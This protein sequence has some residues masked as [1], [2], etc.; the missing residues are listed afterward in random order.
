MTITAIAAPRVDLSL[1]L[2]NRRWV[3]RRRPFNHITARHVFVDEVYQQL[4]Q[5]FDD[6]VGPAP[7]VVYNSKHDF[8][9]APISFPVDPRLSPLFSVDLLKVF[10]D[11]FGVPTLNFVTGGVHRH[12]PDSRHGFPHNDI[13]PEI[14]EETYA[15]PG[16]L[17]EVAEQGFGDHVLGASGQSVRAVA[18]IFFVNNE[19]WQR[20]DGGGTGLYEHW[21]QSTADPFTQ[22]PPYSNSIFAFECTPYSYHSFISN[23]KQRNSFIFFLYRSLENYLAQWGEDGLTQFADVRL[24]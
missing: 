18:I 3:L 13:Q 17:G 12:D 23:K 16:L 22:V 15:G 1:V 2:K 5:V 11:T 8:L 9:S 7:R 14:L 10:A 20:G 6:Y 4:A 24:R 21:S 19:P